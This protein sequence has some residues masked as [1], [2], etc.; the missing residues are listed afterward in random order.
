MGLLFLTWAIIAIPGVLVAFSIQ[1]SELVPDPH[2]WAKFSLIE[3]IVYGLVGL[4]F[5]LI[6]NKLASILGR[7]LDAENVNVQLSAYTALIVG[8][9]LLGAFFVVSGF[10]G[11]FKEIY[12][13]WYF[14]SAASAWQFI[15]YLVQLVLGLFLVL[16]PKLFLRLA[17]VNRSLNTDANDADAG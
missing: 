17:S 3:P 13:F 1:P 9:V 7:R 15:S 6:P 10:R 14:A 11:F 8:L 12:G 4:L 16:R 2:T 5:L